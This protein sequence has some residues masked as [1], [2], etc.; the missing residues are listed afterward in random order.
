MENIQGLMSGIIFIV[1]LSCVLFLVLMLL[2]M[3]QFT[4][5]TYDSISI[6][7]ALLTYSIICYVYCRFSENITS[8]SLEIGDIVYNSLWYKM[9]LKEQKLIILMI[10][11]SQKE[12]RLSGLGLVDC[13]LATFLA[14][15]I[16]FLYFRF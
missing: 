12:F 4:T 3:D 14:V 1:L 9:P 13:S 5:I 6:F 16:N 15:R 11:R 10:Q 7:D 8:K 2:K